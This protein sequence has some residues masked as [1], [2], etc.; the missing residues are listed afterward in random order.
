MSEFESAALE[1]A[2]TDASTDLE[3]RAVRAL[4]EYHTVLPNVGEAR[5]ADD[6]YAV[7]SQSGSQYIV[8][9]RHGSC[10]CPD[11]RHRDGT[12]KHQHR[13]AFAT[14]ETPIPAWIDPDAVDSQLG[15]QVDGSPRLAATDGG[16]LEAEEA[17]G[18]GDECDC[19]ALPEGCPCWSCFRDGKADFEE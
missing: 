3:Q 13:V 9:A 19:A 17:D 12:C 5:G 15:L 14:G 4:T 7:V 2:A 1:R 10:T 11:A 18:D 6:V 8:D 16:A